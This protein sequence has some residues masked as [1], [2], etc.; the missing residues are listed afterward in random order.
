MPNHVFTSPDSRARY[1]Q[2]Y[3]A[4]MREWP[5]P[6]E[7]LDVTTDFG[8]TH[9]VIS[10]PADAPGLL[11][12]PGNFASLTTWQYNIEALSHDYRVFAI[13]TIDDLG[14]SCP[15]RFPGNRSDYA[16]WLRQTIR[17]L[18]LDSASVIGHS[19]G[20]ALALNLALAEPAL[21]DKLALLAPGVPFAP[22]KAA[23]MWGAPMILRPSPWTVRLFFKHASVKGFAS[24][25]PRLNQ[26]IV[27]IPGL[28]SRIPRRPVFAAEEYAGLRVPTL[29]LIGDHEIMYDAHRAVSRA[30]ELCPG[31]KADIV[32]D[33]GHTLHLDQA[34][35]VN[36]KLLA[37]LSA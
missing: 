25:D 35:A 37:F 20:G 17:G 22:P 1:L 13:D 31:L 16:A 19:Y 29:L 36:G 14:K 8:L 18:E 9:G 26:M 21:V 34:D 33:A 3:D 11:L 5:I 10:G 30:Y 2:A 24:D 27:G 23:W 32:A 15:T 7:E 4:A 6:Y 28:H 12:V